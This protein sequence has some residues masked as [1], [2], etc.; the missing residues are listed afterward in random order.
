[1]NFLLLATPAVMDKFLSGYRWKDK[2]NEAGSSKNNEAGSIREMKVK[3]ITS[4]NTIQNI[5]LWIHKY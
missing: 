4:K 5:H 2:D 3:N 1:V